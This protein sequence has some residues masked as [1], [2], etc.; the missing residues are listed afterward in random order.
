MS[1]DR[2]AVRIF[3]AL[4]EPTRLRIVV[5]LGA[6]NERACVC[7]L[8][9]VLDERVYNV[10][11]HLGVLADAGL[12]NRTRRGRWIYYAFTTLPSP[13]VRAL[14]TSLTRLSDSERELTADRQRFTARLALRENAR[15]V[16]W[17]I[18]PGQLRL[19]SARRRPARSAR[20]RSTSQAGG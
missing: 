3:Q 7:E 17:R 13:F 1:T 18:E 2:S 8:S 14:Q 15:C 20:H 16:V 12:L 4:G 9:D 19:T 10:S 6:T 11:R 5:L